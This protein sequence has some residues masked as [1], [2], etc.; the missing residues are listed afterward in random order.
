MTRKKERNKGFAN[1]FKTINK[2]AVVSF[3]L[4]TITLTING[5]YF[6]TKRMRWARGEGRWIRDI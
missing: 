2:M 4:S 6:P 1:N 5:Y 3:C